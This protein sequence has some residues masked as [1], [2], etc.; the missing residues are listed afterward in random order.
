MRAAGRSAN[1]IVAQLG[2]SLRLLREINRDH[3]ITVPNSGVT[4][5]VL[6][7]KH[8]AS[9]YVT[10]NWIYDDLDWARWK[11]AELHYHDRR[12]KQYATAIV[13]L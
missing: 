4:K 8:I 2:G 13:S 12:D 6:V 3:P 1:E 7:V 10:A 5:H 11:Q 9:G